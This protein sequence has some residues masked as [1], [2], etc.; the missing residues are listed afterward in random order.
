MSKNQL[1]FEKN[2]LNIS[3]RVQVDRLWRIIT[4]L[5]FLI[6]MVGMPTASVKAGALAGKYDWHDVVVTADNYFGG[7]FLPVNTIDDNPDNIWL[8]QIDD[9]LP[10]SIW[11][12]FPAE[13]TISKVGLWQA[14]YTE[15]W[16]YR[17]Q[18]Y[19]VFV[20]TDGIAWTSV[21]T[22][23]GTD[24]PASY[25]ETAFTP[26]S[27]K[28]VKITAYYPSWE[29]G[30]YQ[31]YDTAN[32]IGLDGFQAYDGSGTPLINSA[33]LLL[34]QYAL[35]VNISGSG[36]V[37]LDPPGGTYYEGSTVQLNAV[38]ALGWAF[39]GWSDGLSG[40]VNPTSIVMD[41]DKN[42][43]AVFTEILADCYTLTL[44]H[45]GQGTDPTANPPKSAAC[46]T[47]GQ[48]VAG[49]DI[50]LIGA[51][52]DSGWQFSEWTGTD[53]SNSLTMPAN[54]HTAGATY[55]QIEY[56]LTVNVVGNG[57]VSK[58]PDQSTY[59]FG[60]AVQL[61][62]VANTGWVF[63]EWGGGLSGSNNSESITI[64]DNEI[65]TATFMVPGQPGVTLPYTAI[66][67]S[68]NTAA[69]WDTLGGPHN[70]WKYWH[71]YGFLM[72]AL[73][74]DGT[75]YVILSDADI[76]AGALLTNSQPKY[77]ILISL[78][79]DCISDATANQIK[80]FVQAG[81]HAY[82]GSTAWTRDEN[83]QLRG[84]GAL[85]GKYDWHDVVVTA[86]NYFGGAFLPVN[87]I[88]DNPDNIWLNQIDDT[89]PTSIWYEFPA[90]ET[91]SKVGLW[92]A[93][94]T[95]P[96][97]YRL[98]AYEVFVST[99]GIAWTSVATNTGTDVPASYQETAFTPVSAKFVKITAYYPSWEDGVYQ[100]YDTANWIGLDGFQAYD[101]S[102]TPLIN[103]APLLVTENDFALS[104]EMGLLPG[105][106]G[107][108]GTIQK[109]NDDPIVSHMTETDIRNWLLPKAY[110]DTGYSHK[111]HWAQFVTASDATVLLASNGHP[112]LAVNN[113]GAGRFI[114]HSEFSPLA[115]YS[116]Y[117][118]DNFEYGFFRKS[119]EEAFKSNGVPL[120]RLSGWPYPYNAAFKTRHDHFLNLAATEVEAQYGVSGEWLLRTDAA[121]NGPDWQY[122]DEILADGA[123]I[124]SHTLNE[125]TLDS[126]GYQA[127]NDNINQSLNALTAQL[128][129]RPT[130]FVG[131]GMMAF[132]DTSKQ[133]IVDN[134]L[135]T[136]GDMSHGPYPNFALKID[137]A[138]DYGPDAHWN[139]LEIPVG[140]YYAKPGETWGDL[141]YSHMGSMNLTDEIA[142]IE[143]TVDLTYNL[144][145]V[146]NLYD[147]IGDKGSLWIHP[148]TS[149]FEHYIVYS[150]AKPYVW[151][152]DPLEIYDWWSKRNTVSIS[153]SQ[154]SDTQLMVTITGNNTLDPLALDIA[155]PS[156]KAVQAVELDGVPS[157][158]YRVEGSV[159]GFGGTVKI[160]VSSASQVEVIWG[161]TPPSQYSLAVDTSGNGS[162][163][164]DP[165]G[166]TYYEGAT[167][168]LTAVPAPG[169]AFN[170]WSGDLSGATNPSSIIM[171]GNKT[172][173]ANFIQQPN[174]VGYWR[175]DE[176]TG[177]TA[178]DSSTY[179]NN[180]VVNG[181]TWTTGHVAGALS[182]DGTGDRVQILDSTSLSLDTNQVTFAGWIYPTDLSKDWITVIQSSNATASW[183]DWQITAR[184]NDAPTAYRPVFRVD[185]NKNNSIDAG[186]Q[187]QGDIVL[188]TNTWYFIAATYDGT[189]MKFYIDGTLRGTT[190]KTGG[191]I[192]NR[193][194]RN[195]R[196]GDNDVWGMNEFVGKIDEF[197]IYN[198]ALNQ[199]EIQTLMAGTQ[200]TL[201]VN[202]VGSGTVTKDPDKTTYNDGE[203]MQ[204][205]ATPLAG[206]S[207]SAWSGACTGSGVCSVTMDA[208]KTVTAT[209]TQDEYTLT[210]NT[211]G[212][213][214][215]TR[216]NPGPYHYGDV[217]NLTATPDAGWSF[218]GWSANATGGS[219]T[220]NANTIVTATFI[221]KLTPTVTASGGPFTY[222]GASHTATVTGSVAGVVSDVKYNGS[223]TVPTNAGTYV[224][225]ADFTPIDTVTYNSLSNAAAGSITINKAALTVTANNQAILVG[226]PDPA[227]FT[228]VYSGFVNSETATALATKP[229]CTVS[230]AHSAVGA[231]DIV[232]SGGV[233]TNY[234]FSYVKGTLTVTAVINTPTDIALSS[235]AVNQNQPIGTVVGTFS[236]TDPDAGDTFTY[237]L[238]AGAGPTDNASFTISGSQLRTAAVFDFATKSSYS[239]RVRS[240]DSS[241]L[242]FEKEF[243]IT[244][245]SPA[246]PTALVNSVLPTSRS[247]QVGTLATIFNTVVNAGANPAIGVTL[248]MASAP[249]GTFSYQQT[250]CA[251]NATIG[252]LNPSLDVAPGG[253]LCYV[254]SFTP[255]ATFAATNVHIQAQA[256][257]ASSTNLLT[258]INT[259]LL[260][261]TSVA[262]PDIIALTTTTDFHQVACTGANV[263]AVALSNVGVA[264]TGDIT[265]TA[266]TGTAIL[267]LS[268]SISEID[269][270]T[271][272]VIGD[273]V[274]QNVG[275]GENR[276]V[277]VFV[278]FNGCVPF[279]PAVNRIFIEFRDAANNVVGSTSTAVSTDLPIIN[280]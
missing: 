204:L 133:A 79:T 199:A 105:N 15:P 207:F 151:N 125:Y 177:G 78:A 11:Y 223:A 113:Y 121:I 200:R 248:S 22:N 205:A 264:A 134:G 240:T 7:A 77:P 160:H 171:D 106:T 161:D 280:N 86:D 208:D 82:A 42:I 100:S 111:Q 219:V 75:P 167:V 142:Y 169:W 38:P 235:T 176:T 259:W 278:T 85:A 178:I 198:I 92:Q 62:A 236:S 164:L 19:E 96:W 56:T 158:Q 61:S 166:G 65:V 258:G 217:V 191:I 279:D 71:I 130:I 12:E 143:K 222:D 91:I 95:E 131:P 225:T 136:T 137:T 28:F 170:G 57:S 189:A 159:G 118:V 187:V 268:I 32:W 146:I 188:Q 58:N 30:V 213:G 234:T 277:A 190:A 26:V 45:V 52:P 103:S 102:G 249:A 212:N 140:R 41:A 186:E 261:S 228:F 154:V 201:T 138:T 156:N 48:Y 49:E 218:G 255:S 237:S 6:S 262:G 14:S 54:D 55:T 197:R 229:T 183:Y 25:Q 9:T 272:A 18:A 116:G 216:S 211:V 68:E 265:V 83:C 47:D 119:I 227:S 99:D 50:T 193:S 90:E 109:L 257:N 181:A 104:T 202:V 153:P 267:P 209:F 152:T 98:Q 27:A 37:T 163:T 101:G 148:D 253:V 276:S 232:C 254:L 184:A 80:S 29:D 39:S 107:L 226:S 260:R 8:N 233:A 69:H 64:D 4:I 247:V 263:F 180:G 149:P 150:L 5:T 127:A 33:P 203:V 120:V 243:T 124:G 192:P 157:D 126:G 147:H 23:T 168:Q 76:E 231:Y 44:S 129:T 250:D 214:S 172:V 210:I 123:L 70:D 195:I 175:F 165:S 53:S 194:N 24:V 73:R 87:T 66:H 97:S 1:F 245:N 252:G 174:L 224:V 110:T 2:W 34:T 74:S 206:W 108:I 117:V 94:Y 246:P 273:N 67:V 122:L 88:D 115:G 132:R 72:E 16:S 215:V 145:G 244:V 239:I 3:L 141:V 10:T 43:T 271:A 60:D 89:L 230:G 241:S 46:S 36:S 256:S 128:G 17:L 21:A 84:A 135:L 40:A 270:V 51:V 274:L 144:G 81:G 112:T 63:S 139:L 182:F 269:S 59:H 13:E 20:S 93:S 196:I 31:S 179:G 185:W 220:I 266:N 155:I 173:T 162:V 221:N 238:V 242:F 251:T 114:Y 35:A 275:A